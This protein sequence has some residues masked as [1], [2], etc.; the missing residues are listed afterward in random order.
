MMTYSPP[1]EIT[2]EVL[3]LSQAIAYELGI[4]SGVKL[5]SVPVKLRRSNKIQTIQSSLAIE[6]NTLS[7]EQITDIMEGKRVVG[8]S[9]DIKEV[10]N[11]IILY[12]QLT[13]FDPLSIE[14]FLQAHSIL[15]EGLEKESGVWRSGG[16]GIFKGSEVAHMA[17]P[18]KRVPNLMTDLFSFIEK[19]EE[20]SWLIKAC[21][22]HYELEFIHPFIDG[23]GRMGRLWQ[24]LLLMKENSIFEFIPVEA[25]IKHHQHEYYDVLGQCDAKGESTMFIVFALEQ[26]LATL[27][28]Y[29]VSA[30]SQIV[31]PNDRLEYARDRV[32]DEWFSRKQYINVHKDISSATASRDLALG[33]EKK[34]LT[35]KGSKNQVRYKFIG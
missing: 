23:N 2:S 28:E 32:E 7:I 25:M 15:M 9:K 21:V 14:S 17:P 11:A 30:T 6:G 10:Q 4:I 18:A 5:T 3:Q 27:K 22:F 20:T 24:Q 26:I 29:T 33:L 31:H 19:K 1:F 12:D 35:K 8:P 16:V 34:V 13:Q